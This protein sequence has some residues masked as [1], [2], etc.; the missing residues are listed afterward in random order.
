[1]FTGLVQAV[2]QVRGI[3]TTPAGARLVIDGSIQEQPAL[4]DSICVSGCCLTLAEPAERTGEG[5][6]RMSFDVVHESLARTTLGGLRVGSRVN[7][8][9]SCTPQTLLGGH[10]VQGHVEGVGEAVAVQRGDDWRMVI[11]PPSELMPCITPKGSVTIDGV[12]LTVASVDVESGAFG[13]AI[14]PTTLEKT[15]LGG[16]EVGTRCNLETDILAR[17]V[18]HYARHYAGQ[19]AGQDAG[20]RAR[21]SSE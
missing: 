7:L 12:S 21:G 9:T 16:L 20:V 4:G 18:V 1:M 11:R 6:T 19:D 8:E 2:G 14:I 13:V 10:I 15:T 17:T 3:E 5:Q